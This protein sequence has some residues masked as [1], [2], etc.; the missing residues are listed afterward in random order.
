MA[1]NKKKTIPPELPGPRSRQEHPG[2]EHLIGPLPKP[3]GL[4][5]GGQLYANLDF[6]IQSMDAEVPHYRALKSLDELLDRDAQREKDGF[7]RKIRLGKIAKPGKGGSKKIAVIPT[8]EEEKF[9]HDTR[10]SDDEEDQ[11]GQ[12]SDSGESRDTGESTGTAEGE[13]GDVIG[14]RPI[15]PDDEGEGE[16]TGA[17]SGSGGEHEIG[18]TAYELGK[19]LT[20]KFKLPNLKEKGKKKSLT[21]YVYDLTARNHGTGQVLDKKETLKEIIKTNIGLGRFN[22]NEPMRPENFI[23]DHRDYVYRVMAREKDVESQAVVFFVRDYSGSMYGRPTEIVCSQHVMIYSWLM[24]QYKEQVKTRFILHDTE[25]R[26][27][28]DFYTYYNTHVAGGTQIS[29][30][31]E[32]VNK[33]VREENLARDYNI[34]V[35]YGSDGDDM[36]T[37]RA[38]FEKIFDEMFGYVSRLGITIV[39]SAYAGSRGTVFENF[40]SQARILEK[41]PALGRIDVLGEDADD[42]RIIDGIRTLVS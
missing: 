29:T 19:V 8:T 16:G 40:L 24:Y 1:V 35:F 22:P 9:Y 23:I 14:E 33:I 38:E 20:E 27:V 11:D 5:L 25:A 13:E 15:T 6:V 7:R 39:R 32:R 42:P 30:A 3:L 10:T 41:K 26:E 2:A 28:A 4:N 12:G 17:G 21:R 34:Y 18:Q 37:N 36:N 31:F